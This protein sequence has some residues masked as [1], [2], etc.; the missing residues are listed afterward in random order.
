MNVRPPFFLLV[1][2]LFVVV[3]VGGEHHMN[4][5]GLMFIRGPHDSGKLTVPREARAV[6]GVLG[7][8]PG[9]LSAS[10]AEVLD[11]KTEAGGGGAVLHFRFGE[12]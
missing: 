8:D 7:S 5:P 9:A 1:C 4:K 6:T 10:R 11:A 2:L 12:I 3:V